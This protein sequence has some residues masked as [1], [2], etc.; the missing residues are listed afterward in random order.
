A[1]PT[2]RVADNMLSEA[3]RNA[4]QVSSFS[5]WGTTS[6]LRI[7]PQITA[8]GGM[9]NSASWTGDDL[10]HVN[11][12]TSMAAPAVAGAMANLMMYVDKF[13]GEKWMLGD[14]DLSGRVTAADAAKILRVLVE[15]DEFEN[16]RARFQADCNQDG[17]INAAD[18]A[19]IL[20]YLVELDTLPGEIN[21]MKK[22]DR[23]GISEAL[24]LSTARIL[25]DKD[26]VP[27]SPRAQGAG[28][29]KLSHAA[30]SDAYISGALQELGDDKDKTGR[31]AMSFDVVN[32]GDKTLT[33]TVAPTVLRDY[34]STALG[35]T[36]NL[37]SSVKADFTFTTNGSA[38]NHTVTVPPKGTVTV[39]VVI[40]L[41]DGPT[42]EKT[43][44]N[45]LFP[46]GTFV[47]GFVVLTPTVPTGVEPV[48]IHA[49]FLAF[50][51]DWTA[52]SILESA[53][54]GDV[55]NA[56]FN[57]TNPY[58]MRQNVGFNKA[59]IT[60]ASGGYYPS[61]STV[62]NG[63]FL[64]ENAFVSSAYD[65]DKNAISNRN[66]DARSY[67]AERVQG[68]PM[69]LRNAR[70]MIMVVT[71]AQTG[72]VYAAVD[73]PYVRKAVYDA[74]RGGYR[75]QT[76]LDWN[77]AYWD[78]SF[79][80]NGTNA[81]GQLV[82]NNTKV[83]INY[84]AWLDFEKSVEANY[85]ALGIKTT[86]DYSKLNTTAW[87]D[88]KVW[89]YPLTVDNQAPTIEKIERSGSTLNITVSDNQ[90]IMAVL[91]RVPNLDWDATPK[92]VTM[93]QGGSATVSFT[94]PAGASGTVNIEVI[95]YATNRPGWT[96]TLKADPKDDTLEKRP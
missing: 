46:N 10:Y 90:Y 28:M 89:S 56:R 49:T 9:I 4:W 11:S 60:N 74:S 30:Q 66:S 91:V 29:M 95:D 87:S 65:P 68:F 69:Q 64:G 48:A 78:G 71:N 58:L 1:L 7:V 86:A 22:T 18:A 23:A 34:A 59:F 32:L 37:L 43:K 31:Y 73:K 75:N 20:R 8:P 33:Y 19:K 12:G 53:D 6:D 63:K 15:L 44:L 27:Y 16:D 40:M 92:S 5:G 26:K 96:Y 25:E 42:G 54:F 61:G 38:T 76:Y 70:R 57:K 94:L 67:F 36:Y 84:Y 62:N 51:G 13:Y 14:A 47:E 88:W 41:T 50:Y 72:E 17:R 55:I 77:G 21:M 93:T 35:D 45:N 82:A 3:N 2:L 79:V 39:N 83:Q 52:Q 81:A 85:Q 24:A 80:W